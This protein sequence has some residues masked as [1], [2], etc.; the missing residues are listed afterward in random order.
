MFQPGPRKPTTGL[1]VELQPVGPGPFHHGLP[2]L[3]VRKDQSEMSRIDAFLPGKRLRGQLRHNLMII[4]FHHHG[5]RRT[6]PQR[7]A[8]S[9]HVKAPG[10]FQVV[11]GKSQMKE[12]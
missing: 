1:L 10:F 8:E 5:V 6:A 4:E 3:L 12:D 9:I 11:D 7:A 2:L